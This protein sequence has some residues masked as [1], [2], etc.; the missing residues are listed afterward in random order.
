MGTSTYYGFAGPQDPMCGVS[1]ANIVSKLNKRNWKSKATCRIHAEGPLYITIKR[2]ERSSKGRPKEIIYTVSG[3]IIDVTGVYCRDF[4]TLEDALSYANGE[5]GGDL[6]S[7]SRPAEGPHEY[8]RPVGAVVVISGMSNTDHGR[9]P[10]W[11]IQLREPA[12]D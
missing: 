4:P 3:A 1:H 5:D 9:I 6:G 2:G 8:P 12:G 10:N 7:G 11:S